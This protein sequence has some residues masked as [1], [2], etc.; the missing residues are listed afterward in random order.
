VELRDE[1]RARGYRLTLPRRKVLDAVDALVHAT[2]EEIHSYLVQRGDAINASTVYRTVELL[3]DLG[4]V[5]HAHLGHG[6]LT[7]HSTQT[8]KHIHLV[9]RTCGS[10]VDAAPAVADDLVGTLGGDYGFETDLSH[11]T[12]FGRCQEC[13]P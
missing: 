8:S 11:L 10:V 6:A 4:L 3:E 9:C 7:Y 12:I 5:T 1:L 13:R 2:P